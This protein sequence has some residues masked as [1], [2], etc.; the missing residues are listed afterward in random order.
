MKR[1]MVH[2]AWKLMLTDEFIHA[3]KHGVL[4]KCSDGVQRLVFP[5]IFTYAADYPEK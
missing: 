4:I 2:A 5:R 3:W 1:G